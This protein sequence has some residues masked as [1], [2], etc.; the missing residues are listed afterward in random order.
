MTLDGAGI[1][2][3][4]GG[5]LH[6]HQL[7][8]RKHVGSRHNSTGSV[9]AC[10]VSRHAEFFQ[11]FTGLNACFRKVAS[12]R[13]GHARCFARAKCHLKGTVAV[14][15]FGFNLGHAVVGHIHH[16]DRNGIPIISEQT[17]HAHLAAQQP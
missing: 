9:F 3:T 16:C 14:I 8:H 17:H 4:N 1:A 10:D 12:G 7:A 15:C 2:F 13:L 6:V 11:D 5:A